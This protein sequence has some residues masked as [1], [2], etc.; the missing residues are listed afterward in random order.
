MNNYY[1]NDFNLSNSDYWDFYLNK[2]NSN[3]EC[4]PC[5][6][7]SN[8]LITEFDFSSGYTNNNIKTIY[9]SKNWSDSINNGISIDSYGL[10]GIDNGVIP[11]IKNIFDYSNQNLINILTGT[12]LNITSGDT[13]LFLNQVSGSTNNYIY[14]VNYNTNGYLDFKGGFYQGY[15][16]L[17]EYDYQV[18][19]NRYHRGFTFNFELNKSD[20]VISGITGT[21]LN[22]IYPN[23][24]GIFFYM[25][26]RSENKFWSKFKG[27]NLLEC[28]SGSTQ[29]CTNLKE[30]DIFLLDE[31]NNLLPLNPPRIIYKEISNEFLLYGRAN[32]K[33]CYNINKNK[34][35]TLLANEVTGKTPTITISSTTQTIT[36]RLN[37]FLIYGN[38]R[39]NNCGSRFS[40]GYGR[41]TICSYSGNSIDEV[42]INKDL[43]IIDNA[44]AF[45]IKDNG[46]IGYRLLTKNI[47]CVSGVTNTNIQIKEEFSPINTITNDSW[48]NITIKYVTNYYDDCQLK[49]GK[50]R[51]GKLMFYVNCK[52]KFIVKNFPEFIANKLN[53]YKEKQVGVPFNISLGGGTQGLLESM[54]FDGQ[55]SNDLNLEIEK[56]F[57]G[58]FIGS[59]KKFNI[60]NEPLDYC[61]IQNICK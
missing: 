25:G 5:V 23:N 60:Y 34:L 11:Y 36:N 43:D 6:L 45:I 4:A 57:S 42:N 14:S 48:E 35:G 40:D 61:K 16:K 51:F 49:I 30:S 54:T 28:N 38:S 9:N 32:K 56:N 24:K 21:I 47:I 27:N 3:D 13:R 12:T 18:L 19:P 29:Y 10:T 46:S 50:Q 15:Y 31:K 53:D 39:G 59:I 7:S 20:S 58:S 41:E 8:Y 37:P 52:L 22:D 17:N 33:D 26:A 2:D 44:L 1:F 55:D